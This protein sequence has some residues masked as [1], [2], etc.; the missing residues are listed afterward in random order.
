MKLFTAP[1]SPF[2]RKVMACAVA[3][4][5]DRQL[6]QVLLN[7]YASPEDLTA[8]NPL[9]KIPC[10]VTSDGKPMFDSPVI[11]EYLDSVGDAPPMFPPSGGPRWKALKQQATAD[12]ILD[13]AI[14]RR[15]L[16]ALPEQAAL[17]EILGRQQRAVARALD[18]LEQELPHRGLD[19]GTISVTCALG[20]LDFRFPHEPWRP[21]RPVLA[22]WY[23]VMATKPELARTMPGDTA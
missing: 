9:G 23:S 5:I 22:A 7:P 3:R 8:A 15:A 18:M 19:I 21:T 13:A 4:E 6:E 20:Y 1:N 17:A 11:C 12:G 14:T 10:L 2:A 16:G